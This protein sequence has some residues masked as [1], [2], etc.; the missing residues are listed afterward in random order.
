MTPDTVHYGRAEAVSATRS[1]V[2]DV[3]YHSHPERFV[4][5]APTPP[6]L[7]TETWINPPAREAAALAMAQ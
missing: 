3:A 7:P 4:H 6:A 5:R 2:L 1:I